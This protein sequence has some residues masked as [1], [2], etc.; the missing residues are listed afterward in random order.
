MKEMKMEV[1]CT[2]C[3]YFFPLLIVGIER[4]YQQM[5]ILCPSCKNY[6]QIVVL[7]E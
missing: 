3:G 2:W 4:G 6:I 7:G 1:E 5:E